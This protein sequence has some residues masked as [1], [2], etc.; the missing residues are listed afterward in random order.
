MIRVKCPECGSRLKV[1]DKLAGKSRKCPKCGG[2]LQIPPLNEI[3]TDDASQVTDGDG[4]QAKDPSQGA[5]DHVVPPA[6]APERL[7]RHHH[8]LIC[9][10][11]KLFAAWKSNGHGW[12]L[13]TNA[14]FV[15][16]KQNTETLPTQGDFV[17]VELKV[18]DVNG[19]HQL[20][21]I[22][23]YQLDRRWALPVLARSENE[24]LF[25]LS[26]PSGLNKPRKAAV[27]RYL[28]ESMMP[29]MW[30][31]ADA[32]VDYLGNTDFHSQGV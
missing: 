1:K 20:K 4:S 7:T 23:T 29:E 26:G 15:S 25:K 8:Y 18:S 31:A 3:R 32:I 17:L 21:A 9:S 19:S 5:P 16:A 14:G 24:I 30:H 10:T 11:D 2:K 27:M 12:M 22:R 6:E 13:R 28:R